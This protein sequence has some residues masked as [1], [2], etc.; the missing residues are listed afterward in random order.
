MIVGS[1]AG[2]SLAWAGMAQATLLTLTDPT[3]FLSMLNTG[4]F[5]APHTLDFEP[6]S[7][8]AGNTVLS[9]STLGASRLPST[10]GASTYWSIRSFRRPRGTTI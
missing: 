2:L 9:S 10:F 8:Q 1:L 4:P 3:V 6:P 7:A 5:S